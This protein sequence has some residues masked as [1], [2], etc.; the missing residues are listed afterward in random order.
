MGWGMCECMW[1]MFFCLVK[2]N[3]VGWDRCGFSG[4]IGICVGEGI[5][6]WFYEG[7]S[8]RYGLGGWGFFVFCG[9]WGE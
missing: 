8:V 9:G 5:G 4:D 2:I 7:F 3:G 1:V 6:S